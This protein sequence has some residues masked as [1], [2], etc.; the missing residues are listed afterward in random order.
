MLFIYFHSY[1]SIQQVFLLSFLYI[2]NVNYTHP[3]FTLSLT[4]MSVYL[5]Q[6]PSSPRVHIVDMK[7]SSAE[8]VSLARKRKLSDAKLPAK[9]RPLSL[10]QPCSFHPEISSSL[11]DS[12]DWDAGQENIPLFAATAKLPAS[13]H[14]AAER[15]FEKPTAYISPI[16]RTVNK[17]PKALQVNAHPN[18]GYLAD[19]IDCV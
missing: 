8:T 18:R 17:A 3:I 10:V 6:L 5:L 15:R 7:S 1:G 16:S 14:L 11:G 4:F 13:P 9:P 19:F 2:C 12:P